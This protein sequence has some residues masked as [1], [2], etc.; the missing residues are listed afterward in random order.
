MII[1]II[2]IFFIITDTFFFIIIKVNEF[3]SDL[4]QLRLFPMFKYYLFVV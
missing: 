3:S 4:L 2:I 1:E